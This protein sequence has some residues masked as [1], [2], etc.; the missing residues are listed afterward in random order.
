M[1]CV[2]C[3]A[4][5][6]N[7]SKHCIRCGT[8]IGDG[9]FNQKKSKEDI[10]FE[11]IINGEVYNTKISI[12]YLCFNF[13]YAFYKKMYIEGI[14]SFCSLLI[15][16]YT[17]FNFTDFIFASLGS[18]LLPIGFLIWGCIGINIKFIFD[19]DNMYFKSINKFVKKTILNNENASIEKLQSICDERRKNDWISMIVS[20][21]L[22]MFFIFDI[23]GGVII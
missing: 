20:I 22:F 14:V 16:V 6:P 13:L 8:L 17:I 11:Y 15:I 23:M 12:K 7:D 9:Y 2:K 5:L 3:N 1:K 4:N 10:L 18:L 19:F 21:F